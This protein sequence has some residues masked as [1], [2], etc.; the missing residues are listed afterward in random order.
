MMR[1]KWQIGPAAVAALVAVT[2]GTDGRAAE[3]CELQRTDRARTPSQR[4]IAC[5][6]GVV[7]PGVTFKMTAGNRP[8]M[9]HPVEI[10]YGPVA[11]ANGDRYV[12][13]AALPADV[14]LVDGKI[15]CTSCHDGASRTPKHVIDPMKLCYACHRM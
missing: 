15:A 2:A 3:T 8:G 1:R 12:P 14:P 11:E 7:G 10:P 9:D 4:C 5:H 6:D 13:E